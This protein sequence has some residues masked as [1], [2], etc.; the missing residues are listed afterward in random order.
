MV[1]KSNIYSNRIR[2]GTSL[3]N[4]TGY[5]KTKASVRFFVLQEKAKTEL[6]KSETVNL[7]WRN[8]QENMASQTEVAKPS[9]ITQ[10]KVEMEWIDWL[11]ITSSNKL[12]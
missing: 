5:T 1:I 2:G 11:N 10:H 8:P 12:L 6:N 7:L 9:W 3:T 4:Q